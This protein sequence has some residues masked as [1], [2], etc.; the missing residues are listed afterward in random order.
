MGHTA[1]KKVIQKPETLEVKC[2]VL[3]IPDN[4]MF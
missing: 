1:M 2:I 3:Q 4:K